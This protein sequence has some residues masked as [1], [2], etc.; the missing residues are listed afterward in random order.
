MLFPI[1][2]IPFASK[3]FYDAGLTLYDILGA[4]HDGGWHRRLSKAATLELAPTLRPRGPPRRPPL[5]DGVEDDARYTLAVARTAHGRRRRGGH[6]GPR[7]RAPDRRHVRGDRRRSEAEDLMTGAA[8]AHPDPGRSST[9]PASGPPSP[10]TRSSG[11]L[12]AHPAEPRRPPRRAARPDPEQDRADH[13]GPG[14]GRLPRPVARSLADRHDRRAVRR[15]GRARPSAAGWE[16][17]RLLDTVNATMDVGP[18]AG[19]RGRHVRRAAA[20]DRA[21]RR[22]DRQ[23]VARAPRDGRV[24]R[25]RPHRRRQ[26][27]DLSS[28]GARRHRHRPRACGGARQRPSDTAERRLVGAADTDALARIAG[29]LSTIAAVRDVGP[30]TRGTTGRPPRD[31]G[32]GA[33]S[34]WGRSSTCCARSFRGAP[35]SRPRSRGPSATNWPSRSTT[36]WRAGPAS[37][38]SCPDRGAAIAP[39]VA[40]ILGAELGW[41]EARQRSRSRSY[42]ATARREYSVAPPGPPGPHAAEVSTTMRLTALGD[43]SSRRHG[44]G[45][46][47]AAMEP[48]RPAARVLR[49]A[50][51]ES[52]SRSR[53][54]RSSSRSWSSRIAWRAGWFAAARRHPGRAGV[55][56]V[57]ALL[58]VGLPLT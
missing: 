57:V 26:V 12:A 4:R 32:A 36:S 30:E 18:D 58:A 47:I 1:Y 50:V 38:R 8:L 9:R 20:A 5:H 51:H 56:L 49:R 2:G 41:G 37:P 46:I 23:G 28:D 15:P 3:A 17:D 22:L 29:E 33:S 7:D 34:R 42:L 10:T 31:G 25:R 43:T 13:P 6:E 45:S 39:R 11:R 21:V 16:V 19:R 44:D 35:S 54:A 24:E 52:R 48:G 14:Q 53:S 27:H 40:Q 55:L